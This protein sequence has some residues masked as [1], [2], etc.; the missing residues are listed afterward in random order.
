MPVQPQAPIGGPSAA[1]SAAALGARLGSLS[2]LA[3]KALAFAPRLVVALLAL[4]AG[5]FAARFAAG[6]TRRLAGRIHLGALLQRVGFAGFLARAQPGQGIEDL[7][8]AVV[9][10]LVQV[11]ALLFALDALGIH[12]A[13]DLLGAVL[14]F[15]PRLVTALVALVAG[16]WL[17]QLA[18]SLA[19][20]AAAGAGLDFH[21]QLGGTVRSLILVITGILALDQLGVR[22]ELL[23]GTFLNL[24]SIAAAGVALAF[25]LGARDIVADLLAGYYARQRFIPGETLTLG[26]QEGVLTVIGPL[27]SELE[28]PGDRGRVVVP[29]RNLLG[30]TV[31]VRD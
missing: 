6:L 4:I 5:Y 8:A 12:A 26:E 30:S 1:D 25:G 13:M 15:L 28:A 7:L 3:E 18:G 29:N 27:N 23:Q 31:L 16:A 11:G 20:A 21:R 10:R 19:A 22:T 2:L 17:A 9:R 24:L 14:G